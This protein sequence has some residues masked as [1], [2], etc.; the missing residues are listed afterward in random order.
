MQQPVAADNND[1]AINAVALQQAGQQSV[2]QSILNNFLAGGAD[3]D[4]GKDADANSLAEADVV[5]THD[6]RYNV[7]PAPNTGWTDISHVVAAWAIS[8][9]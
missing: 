9:P 1:V 3:E 6:E 8:L 5:E 4:D 7:L 2:A